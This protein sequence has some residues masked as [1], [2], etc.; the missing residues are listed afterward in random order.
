MVSKKKKDLSWEEIGSGIAKNI[1]QE[2]KKTKPW[3]KSWCF[4]KQENCGGG[5][6]RLIF[7]IG[8]MYAL[9]YKG[10]LTGI[11]GLVIALIII[12]FALMRF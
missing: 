4:H 1:E 10:L 8:L 12:G 9:H 11:P 5:F 2:H 7:I 3:T 6:G